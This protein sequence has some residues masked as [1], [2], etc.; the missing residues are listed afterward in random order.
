MKN[1]GP[2]LVVITT[3]NNCEYQ[4]KTL[5]GNY[6]NKLSRFLDVDYSNFVRPHVNCPFLQSEKVMLEAK[7]E[8]IKNSEA[9]KLE[10]LILSIFSGHKYGVDTYT[11]EI[12]VMSKNVITL[13]NLIDFRE[14]LP[15]YDFTIE[16][17]DCDLFQIRL[18]KKEIK[19]D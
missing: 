2:K 1:Q 12:F 8:E 5:T 14:K 4:D 6:C 13:D 11:N 19:N 18:L 9:K 16:A 10:K 15:D 7:L 17:C 3:C